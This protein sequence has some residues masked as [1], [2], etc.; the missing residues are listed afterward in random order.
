LAKGAQANGNGQSNTNGHSNGAEA[1]QK[2]NGTS[3]LGPNGA[4]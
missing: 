4:F 2:E 3:G 1:A